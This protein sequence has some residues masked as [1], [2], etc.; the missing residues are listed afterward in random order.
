LKEQLAEFNAGIANCCNFL[1]HLSAS[2]RQIWWQNRT[3]WAGK[4]YVQKQVFTYWI[5]F[6]NRNAG[7]GACCL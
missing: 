2:P 3:V 6:G 1:L 7:I 5:S 4:P